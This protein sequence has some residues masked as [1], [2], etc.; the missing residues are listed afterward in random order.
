MKKRLFYGATLLFLIASLTACGK[1]PEPTEKDVLKAL[2]KEGYLSEE[3]VD[4]DLC[5]VEMEEIEIDDD[6]EGSTVECIVSVEEEYVRRSTEYKIKFKIRDDKESWR[7]RKVTEN[8][9]TYE[10]AN[11]ITEDG[12]ED[13]L[14]WESISFENGTIYFYN[15]TTTYTVTSHEVRGTD[16]VDVVTLEVSGVSGYKTLTATVQYTLKYSYSYDSGYW[17]IESKEV[18]NSSVSYVDGYEVTLTE[19][20]VVEDI[21]SK[22]YYI[23]VLDY[24][25]YLDDKE[26]IISNVVIG[27][28]EYYDNYLYVPVTMNVATEGVSFD[29]TYKLTYY[30]NSYD[31]EWSISGVSVIGYA[32]FDAGIV[33]TWMGT[34]DDGAVVLTVNNFF[35]ED[36]TSNLDVVVQVTTS[37]GQIFSYSAYVDT[38]N[39]DSNYLVIYG[40]EWITQPDGN[41]YKE[42]FKGYI[43][44][45]EYESSTNSYKFNLKK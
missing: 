31:F 4:N 14:Y 10:L 45:G 27:D 1:V 35:H 17:S 23:V 26:T 12:L 25:Y 41:Y 32:N 43:E 34:S 19:E 3:Q 5:S 13:V 36:Y 2:E 30:L 33:G 8:E 40:Y 21:L 11:P 18:V 6:K 42:T 20:R 38:Y 29:V 37:N 16:M 39:P 22:K 15:D 9:T 7:V 44:N 24:Y 28:Y